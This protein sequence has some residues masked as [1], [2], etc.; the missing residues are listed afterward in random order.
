MSDV[1]QYPVLLIHGMGFRDGKRIQYWGRIPGV[2]EKHG[3]PVFHA[4]QD[5][6]GSMEGNA[7]QIAEALDD[8]LKQTGA[9]KVNVIAHSKGGLEARYLISS[10]GYEDKIASLTTLATPHHGSKTVDRLMKFPDGLIRFGCKCVDLWYRILGDKEPDTYQAIQIFR[11]SYMEQ[12]NIHNQDMPGIYYQSYAFVMNS[13]FSDCLMWFPHLVVKFFE[14]ENDGLLTPDSAKWTNFRGVYRSN[15][16]RGIS[17]CDEV[18]LRRRHFTR[19]QG[20]GI[21]DI[22]SFYLDIVLELAEKGF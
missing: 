6:N 22:T 20:D 19:K 18:D 15:S 14:G 4:F 11:T 2:L 1:I 3:I 13:M 7:R 21:S 5:S 8:V 12:F 10:M 9:E 17:H 16:R